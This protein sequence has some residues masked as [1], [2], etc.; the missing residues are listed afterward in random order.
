MADLIHNTDQKTSLAYQMRD[1]IRL[2]SSEVRSVAQTNSPEDREKIFDKLIQ[3]TQTYNQAHEQLE[4]LAANAREDEVLVKMADA[5]TRSY[6]AYDL[7]ARNIYS[8][9]NNPE[10]LKSALG[11]VQLREL[12]LLNHLNGLVQLEKELSTEALQNNQN[13]YKKTLSWLIAT[14]VATFIVSIIISGAVTNRVTAA[15][16]RIKHLAAHDDLTGLHNRRSFE[17]ALNRTMAN[18]KRSDSTKALMY[19]DFD[20][21]KIVNDSVG[22]H[23]GDQL[24]IELT[25]L[26]QQHLS[27]SDLFARVG[28][29]EF[30]I[31]TEGPDL[32]SIMALAENLRQRVE[33]YTFEYESQ[34]FTVSLSIGVIPVTGEEKNIETLLQDVDSAC[35]VAK[36]TGRNRVHLAHNDDVEVVKYR[37]DIAGIQNIRSALANDQFTLFYQPVHEITETG[38]EMAHCEILLRIIDEHGQVLSPA[39]FIPVAEKY[40]LM[41]E[42]DRWVITNVM[43]WVAK[44]QVEREIPRFLINLSG[45]SFID[46][47]FLNFVINEFER[48]EIDPK[49]IAFEI[50]ETAA[51]DNIKQANVFIDELRKI[52]CRFA[53]DDFGTGFSTF[54]YLKNLTIDYLKIDGS[55][56]RNIPTDRVDREMVRAI[57]HIGQTV[58]AKT[59]AEFVEDHA[60]IDIL[61]QIG[62]EYAQGFGIQRPE[63]LEKLV[64]RLPRSEGELK[65]WRRAS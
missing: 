54:E 39:N 58:G 55:L 31:I 50:T 48:F 18:A 20:R 26:L 62:V 25:G 6:E 12:V 61:R 38:T 1:A 29:D 46:E 34:P 17:D 27:S 14:V 40:N 22:H 15:N 33:E 28:G 60:T 5:S 49:N 36:Q 9:E 64:A 2:R 19:I 59:I 53:L 63:S 45:L 43:Q 4:K 32:N 42:I 21:F 23:A 44:H 13:R 41:A 51:M 37:N 35:Y 47:D 56:V 8:V 65:E 7:A 24:L 10:A 11:N 52:G 57:H 3:S 16:K 30:A